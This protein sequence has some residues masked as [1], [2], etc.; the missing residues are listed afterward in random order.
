MFKLSPE[1]SNKPLRTKAQIWGVHFDYQVV[2]N[3]I[4]SWQQNKQTKSTLLQIK[5]CL[6]KVSS[7]VWQ[8][9]W[10]KCKS[11][12]LKHFESH[13]LKKNSKIFYTPV[14]PQVEKKQKGNFSLEFS[15]LLKSSL[16]Y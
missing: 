12:V 14:F 2:L 11:A 8:Y 13:R 3:C 9:V 15:G 16:I 1:D 7:T 10:R 4:N 6:S 5:M